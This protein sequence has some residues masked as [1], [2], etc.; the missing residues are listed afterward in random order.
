MLLQVDGLEEAIELP[1]GLF[2]LEADAFLQLAEEDV[3]L[4]RQQH[5]VVVSQL[6]PLL[7]D[8]AADLLITGR[9]GVLLIDM[10]AVSMRA[11]SLIVQISEQFPDVVI[12][13]AG[14]RDDEPLLV[15]MISDGLVYRF[16]HKPVSARRVGMFLQ[17]AARH[18]LERRDELAAQDPSPPLMRRLSRPAASLKWVYLATLLTAI[19]VD[20][21]YFVP[22]FTERDQAD[23]TV[24]I[25]AQRNPVA[26]A[27]PV[28]SRARAALAAGRYESPAGR[29]A[30]DLFK[31]VL[32]EQPDHAEA[33]A[34]LDW[35]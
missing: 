17:A 23:A 14:M 33:R 1:F 26:R 6:G 29:N 7:F 16:M 25:A 35:S 5:Q 8:E 11:D 2:L 18:H 3:F 24:A 12:C 4:A 13:V 10:R 19:G 21:S 20:A 30:L 27:N 9:C 34:G 32:L 31:A 22:N 15:P 28:L